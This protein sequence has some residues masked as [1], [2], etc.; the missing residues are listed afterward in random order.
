VPANRQVGTMLSVTINEMERECSTPDSGAKAVIDHLADILVIEVLRGHF[1][2]APNGA[3]IAA[4]RDSKVG[5]ALELFHE[6]PARD[7]SVRSLASAVHMSRSAFAERF[8]RLV[9]LAPMQYVSKW[10]MELA[11]A[12]LIESNSPI[13]EVAAACG[14]ENRES[15]SK[16]FRKEF[17]LSP[18]AVRHR[19]TTRS[20]ILPSVPGIHQG[21]VQKILYSPFEA[22]RLRIQN[23]ALFVDVRD[24]HAYAEGH[25]PGAVNVPELFYMLSFTTAEG[26]QAMCD[27]IE[28]AL[29]SSGIN[30]GRTV[31]FVEDNLVTRFGSSCRGFFQLTLFGHH[32]VG[33]LDGGLEHWVAQGFPTNIEPVNAE[34]SDLSFQ[35]RRNL[36]A[37]VDDV[38]EALKH[39]E[40]KLLDNRDQEEW[41]G[42]VSAPAPFYE[43]DFLPRSGRIPGA[44]W[45]EWRNFM[46]TVDGITHFERPERIRALC[47]Q[48]GLYPGDEV[49]VYCFKGARSSNTCVALQL[50][51]FRHVRNYYGSFNEWSRD[52]VLPVNAEQLRL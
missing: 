25:I 49:I 28:K 32:S 46:K 36:I 15:L 24:P 5:Q 26:L 10:R 19:E 9:G 8:H 47:A 6:E 30:P 12:M 17:G 14:Y 20:I 29:I 34:R 7:W 27:D 23:R 2:E 11:R 4:V 51:G 40:V 3:Y 41:L 35:I 37:T 39:S 50:A 33:I 18:T 48:V 43:P 38:I 42:T 16:A 22:N 45:I 1:R 52:A 13:G 31:I 44:R 21:T